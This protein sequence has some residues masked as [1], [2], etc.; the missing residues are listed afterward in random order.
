MAVIL[1]GA[2]TVLGGGAVAAMPHP[3]FNLHMTDSLQFLVAHGYVVLFLWVL[4]EQLGLP[5]PAI[6]MLLGAGAMAGTGQM[7]L[8]GSL[9]LTTF[10]SLL[11]DL[12]W[13]TMGRRRGGKVLNLLCRVSLEPDSC[14]RRTENLFS[15]YGARSLLVAKFLPGLNTAAP[16]MA[17]V[18]GMGLARFLLCDAA[19]ALLWAGTFLALGY[20]FSN[21]LELLARVALGLGTWLLVLLVAAMV[22]YVVAKYAERRRFQRQLYA[23]RVS[24]QELKH[25]LDG[26]E[27]VFLLDLRHPLDFL[28][29]PRVL[30]GAIRMAPEELEQRHQEI[31]RDREVILY[32]T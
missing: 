9:L 1:S 15:R 5:L 10:A 2:A 3:A 23:D 22:A 16:P 21:Q 27:K 30:P 18:V 28:P 7:S 24:P 29:D 19:G 32:C 17:G 12:V 25:R 4:M 8:A 31:P 13:Y 20:A 26:G 11:S 6:P 14:V